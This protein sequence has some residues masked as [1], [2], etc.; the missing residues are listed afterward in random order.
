MTRLALEIAGVRVDLRG[1]EGPPALAA[2]Y[3]PFQREAGRADATIE[4]VGGPD[5]P[6]DAP[7]RVV[8]RAGRWTI[9]GRDDLGHLDV[10]AGAGV[11]A[12]DRRV[13]ALDAFVRALVSR[14]VLARGGVLVHAAALRVGGAAHLVPGSS[15]AGKST[16]AS[17][18][19]D[20]IADELAAVLPRPDGALL[21]HG[22][23]WWRGDPRPAPLAAVYALAWDIERVE[24][25]PRRDALR[26]VATH[27]ALP[28]DDPSARAAAF[29]AAGRIAAAAPFRRLSF[30]R[31]S[32]VD[33]LLRRAGSAAA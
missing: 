32:D 11:V 27:L 8:E 3:G 25:L 21:V 17:L 20:G 16:L 10:A 28:V 15:G 14:H 33:A 26:H 30:R 9:Q 12:L 24:E 4:L 5:A 2:R 23:P 29:A 18:A 6:P 13:N 22:T 31:D 19:R 7:P 1:A